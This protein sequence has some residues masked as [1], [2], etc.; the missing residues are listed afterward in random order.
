MFGLFSN[1]NTTSS[2]TKSP[3]KP[4]FEKDGFKIINTTAD[5]IVDPLTLYSEHELVAYF[6]ENQV[7]SCQ[8][9]HVSG[10]IMVQLQSLEVDKAYE[11]RGFDTAL[12]FATVKI[13]KHNNLGIQVCCAT[14]ETM[15]FY[16]MAVKS[17]IPSY[18]YPELQSEYV[19]KKEKVCRS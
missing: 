9:K 10:N 14:K 5:F 1:K 19:K 2:V 4:I 12:F 6:N 17:T 3:A 18:L 8:L 11:N 16:S 15:P 13:A 7:G